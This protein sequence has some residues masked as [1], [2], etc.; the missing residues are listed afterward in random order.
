MICHL[1]RYEL[2]AVRNAALAALVGIGRLMALALGAAIRCPTIKGPA[3]EAVE[4]P[5]QEENCHEGNRN[6]KSAPHST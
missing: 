3:C 6:V 1:I 2:I 4:G 5:D